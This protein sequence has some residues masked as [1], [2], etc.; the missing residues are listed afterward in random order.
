MWRKKQKR[1]VCVFTHRAFGGL[2]HLQKKKKKPT[3]GNHLLHLLHNSFFSCPEPARLTHGCS[4]WL[5]ENIPQRSEIRKDFIWPHLPIVPCWSIKYH[6]YTG[7][8]NQIKSSKIWPTESVITFAI[9]G[10][11]ALFSYHINL[12][13]AQIFKSWHLTELFQVDSD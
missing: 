12:N 13:N 8:H 5:T 4:D 1:T 6:L 3:I 7:E 2:S 9:R 10:K 11:K